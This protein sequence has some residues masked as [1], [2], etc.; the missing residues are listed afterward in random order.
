MVMTVGKSV[1]QD[2]GRGGGDAKDPADEL[3][4]DSLMKKFPKI[5]IRHIMMR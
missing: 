2:D 1:G 5:S 4:D 3:Q